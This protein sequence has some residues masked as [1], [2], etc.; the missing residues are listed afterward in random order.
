MMTAF[1]RKSLKITVPRMPPCTQ[2]PLDVADIFDDT[3]AQSIFVPSNSST[4]TS[5]S[6][7]NIDTELSPPRIP[8]TPMPS[9]LRVDTWNLNA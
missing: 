7:T 1:V 5:T 9:G 8:E 2:L 3:D 4:G 6:S